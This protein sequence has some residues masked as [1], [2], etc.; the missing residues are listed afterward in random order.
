MQGV[1]NFAYSCVNSPRIWKNTKNMKDVI[2]KVRAD[3]NKI[4]MIN[5]TIFDLCIFLANT[6]LIANIF[7]INFEIM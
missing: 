5:A 1:H 7:S 2:A 4:V 3:L 6:S